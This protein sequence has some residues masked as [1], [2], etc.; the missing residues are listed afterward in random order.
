MTTIGAEVPVKSNTI[1]V[2]GLTT[3]ARERQTTTASLAAGWTM[4]KAR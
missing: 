1:T 4:F 3:I 2:S